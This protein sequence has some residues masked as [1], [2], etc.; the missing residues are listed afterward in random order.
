V[1][2]CHGRHDDRLRVVPHHHLHEVHVRHRVAG[3]GDGRQVVAVVCMRRRVRRVAGR[4]K[5]RGV[6]RVVLDTVPGGN[7][8]QGGLP[9]FPRPGPLVAGCTASG[10]E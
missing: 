10:K 1:R 4:V 9:G 2:R 5:C 8:L 6:R 3:P 7:R